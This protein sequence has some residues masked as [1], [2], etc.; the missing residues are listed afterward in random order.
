MRMQI[1]RHVAFDTKQLSWI[2]PKGLASAEPKQIGGRRSNSPVSIRLS[3]QERQLVMEKAKQ[4]GCSVNAYIKTS[5]LGTTHKAKLDPELKNV[6]LAL[7]RELTAQ[8]RNLNQIA[9]H[10]NAGSITHSTAMDALGP[11]SIALR[12]THRLVRKALSG[13]REDFAL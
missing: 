9:K 13:N 3:K 11:L 5:M 2:V 4:S 8:G 7:N 12:D 1:A 10:L 6:L